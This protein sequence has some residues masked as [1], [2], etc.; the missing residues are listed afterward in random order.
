MNPSIIQYTGIPSW[1]GDPSETILNRMFGGEPIDPPDDGE[2][3]MWVEHGMRSN[4]GRM[5]WRTFDEPKPAEWLP[6]D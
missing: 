2:P 5:Y 1:K 3:E 6:G 4:K